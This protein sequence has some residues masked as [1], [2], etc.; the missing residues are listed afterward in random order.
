MKIDYN[1]LKKGGFLKQIQKDYYIMRLRTK[2]GNMT[3]EQLKG[4][5]K[6]ADKY[7]KGYVHFTT[8]QGVEI[9]YVHI[10]Q[11]ENIKKEISELGL[12]TGTCGPRIRS[13]IACPG[14]EVCGYGLINARE[15][16][17]H[18][19]EVFFGRE[20]GKKTKLAISGCPNSC[21]KPQEN[22]FGFVGAVN[23][24]FEEEKCISC[25]ICAKVCPSKA[26]TMV[27]GKPILD[28]KK[29]IHEGNCIASCPTD[30]WITEKK[31]IH[32]YVGGKIG[33]FP[34]LGQLMLQFVPEE[35]VVVVGEAIIAAFSKLGQDGERIAN[36]VNRVGLDMFREEVL[37]EVEL[38]DE[39]SN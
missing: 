12:L 26:I 3:T 1:E 31:G 8:R 11:Y 37:K 10:N 25:G 4:V 33:R 32:V 19:D 9:P 13:V 34:Q 18:L 38:R 30:A 2:G 28:E 16:G 22:D 23:P 27:E 20:V 39:Q 7:G 35:Q 6:L 15:I 5:T 29:C 36:T 14:N 21:T 17:S 24:K